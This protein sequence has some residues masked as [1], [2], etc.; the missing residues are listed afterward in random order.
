MFCTTKA[1]YQPILDAAQLL[2]FFGAPHKGLETTDLESMVESITLKLQKGRMQRI[3]QSLKEDSEFLESYREELVEV[4]SA[5][6][7]ISLYETLL[8]SVVRPVG[9]SPC[10]CSLKIL[11]I[12]R[13]VLMEDTLVEERMSTFMKPFESRRPCCIY[14]TKRESPCRVT[15]PTSPNSRLGR[16]R[17]TRNFWT[18]SNPLWTVE[19][20]LERL[21]TPLEQLV[22]YIYGVF[23]GFSNS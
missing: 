14:D 7:I 3:V 2:I 12:L 9:P 21:K 6:T 17:H 22:C 1:E 15:I 23:E 5:R 20:P 13:R 16:M 4:L 11:I 8:S 10:G 19:F 18:T